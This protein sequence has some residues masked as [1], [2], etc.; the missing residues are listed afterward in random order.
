LPTMASLANEGGASRPGS[1]KAL[2]KSRTGS[3]ANSV[4]EIPIPEVSRFTPRG[5]FPVR[6][7]LSAKPSEALQRIIDYLQN[8]QVEDTAEWR[9]RQQA[10]ADAQN[11]NEIQSPNTTRRRTTQRPTSVSSSESRVKGDT[12]ISTPNAV[13][14]T[15]PSGP[16]PCSLYDI[17]PIPSEG[18][19]LR[20]CDPLGNIPADPAIVLRAGQLRAP[21]NDGVSGE[22]KS[23]V[24]LTLFN[25]NGLSLRNQLVPNPNEVTCATSFYVALTPD[26][27]NFQTAIREQNLERYNR[28]KEEQRIIFERSEQAAANILARKKEAEIE[29]YLRCKERDR[30]L[31]KEMQQPT[32]S[33]DIVQ[34]RK[35]ILRDAKAREQ[36]QAEKQQKEYE[37]QVAEFYHTF[38]KQLIRQEMDLTDRHRVGCGDIEHSEA[39]GW[40]VLIEAFER[41]RRDILSMERA[42]R[43]LRKIPAMVDQIVARQ[44]G[45]DWV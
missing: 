34:W 18:L 16:T 4:V 40:K 3:V 29:S 14:G 1:G 11:A 42:N 13:V 28:E 38:L 20:R 19:T 45:M 24:A 30:E 35:D 26:P 32:A 36:R 10:L 8:V 33:P 25:M 23:R 9:N 44:R 22:V 2:P 6:V 43:Q 31:R 12:R 21:T 17:D 41:K 15:S 5:P 39:E 37:Q 7:P 27:T